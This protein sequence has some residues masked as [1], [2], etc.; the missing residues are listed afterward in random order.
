MSDSN[1]IVIEL[2]IDSTDYSAELGI[3]IYLDQN[4]IHENFHV[5][6]SYNFSHKI[7]DDDG[8]HELV[9][10]LFGK[11][12]THTS[13]N[14]AGE[15][16]KDAMLVIKNVEFDGIS[17]S[18]ILSLVSQYQHDFNGTQPPVSTR[19]YSD[20]GCNGKVTMKFTTPVYLWLLENM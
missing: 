10:E 16:I 18:Q 7:S 19:F 8:E 11:K 20:L 13:I 2:N 15:I 12:P 9:Y 1:E 14:E 5:K 6:E 3:R 4:L 17:V